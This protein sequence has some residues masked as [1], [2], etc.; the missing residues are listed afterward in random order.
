M[1]AWSVS[2]SWM[3]AEVGHPCTVPTAALQRVV[4]RNQTRD[5]SVYA[6]ATYLPLSLQSGWKIREMQIVT[7]LIFFP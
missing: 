5:V 3:K 2:Q 6:L 1:P 4:Q 7:N